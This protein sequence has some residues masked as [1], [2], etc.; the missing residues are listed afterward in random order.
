M[1]IFTCKTTYMTQKHDIFPER[2]MKTIISAT[3]IFMYDKYFYI[4]NIL[5]KCNQYEICYCTTFAS[6]VKVSAM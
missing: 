1:F 2:L 5:F 6:F 4:K 3:I